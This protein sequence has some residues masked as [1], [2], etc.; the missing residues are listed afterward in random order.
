MRNMELLQLYA[1]DNLLSLDV[2]RLCQPGSSQPAH[3][4]LTKVVYAIVAAASCGRPV[5]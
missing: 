3:T 5:W 2:P 1:P 4:I